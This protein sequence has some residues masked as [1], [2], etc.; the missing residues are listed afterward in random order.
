MLDQAG[1][2]ASSGSA[3]T[4]GSSDPSHVLSA[5]GLPPALAAGSL[6]LTLG[7]RNTEEDVD[8][9]LGVLPRIVEKIRAAQDE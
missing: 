3:C 6:R 8:A 2:C 1:I 5:I 9:I 7:A 4:A